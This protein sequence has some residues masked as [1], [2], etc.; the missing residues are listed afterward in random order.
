M[1]LRRRLAEVHSGPIRVL[2]LEDDPQDAELVEDLLR[3]ENLDIEVRHADDEVG[4][5]EALAEF[6]PDIVLSDLSMPGF[7]GH[8]ALAIVRE[9]APSLPFLFV[10]GTMGEEAA[11]EA[12]RQGAT[13]YILKSQPARLAP[14]TIRALVEAADQRARDQAEQELVRSQRYESLALLAGGLSHDLRNI[15]QPLLIAAPMIAERAGTDQGVVKFARMI[16]TCAKRGMDMVASM[17]SFARGARQIN[18]SLPVG[19]LFRATEL[20]LQGT[21]PRSMALSVQLSDDGLAVAANETELQQCLLNLCLNAIQAMPPDG[22][23]TL[24]ADVAELEQADINA[25]EPAVP[26]RYLRLSVIDTGVGMS[27]EVRARLFTPFFTTKEGGTGLGLLSCRRIV[28]NH[29]GVMRV[30]ST[31][32]VG[33]R[34]EIYLPMAQAATERERQDY[35]GRGRHVL[36]VSEEA[37]RLS[38]V[39]DGLRLHNYRCTLA[40]SGAAA[41]VYLDDVPSAEVESEGAEQGLPHAVVLDGEMRLLP[42]ARVLTELRYRNYAGLVVLAGAEDVPEA[43]RA[44]LQLVEVGQTGS[45]PDLLAALDRLGSPQDTRN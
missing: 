16:E 28:D 10:S 3:E 23:L 42:V 26:G 8:R 22:T 45:L 29:Q 31:P 30:H 15:L 41:L 35:D 32:G 2:H 1:P 25:D 9:S 37:G 12:L 44:G 34:F 6:K 21:R 24:A 4:L 5:R 39:A 20:L 40:R 33:T 43:A 7:S 27:E 11:I 14:A 36:V 19:Q 13:D 38:I 17:L 18:P